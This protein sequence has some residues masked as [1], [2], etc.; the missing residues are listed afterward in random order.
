MNKI[1]LSALFSSVFSLLVTAQCTPGANY[2][3]SL[4]GAWPDTTT[5]FP[6][7]SFGVNYVTDLNFKVPSDAGDIDPAYA[8][9]TIQDFTVDSVVGL[10]D[11][12]TY[13]CNVTSCYYTGGSNGC[14][15]ISGIPASSGSHDITIHITANL[16][17]FGFPVA[18]PY[19]FD[20]YHINVSSLGLSEKKFELIS[21]YPNPA[22]DIVYLKEENLKM[23]HIEILDAFGKTV[24]VKTTDLNEL[25]ISSLDKGIYIIKIDFK[26]KQETVRFVKS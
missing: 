15:Q 21:L 22:Q 24:M 11:G 6:P 16:L 20:G 17:F 2:A 1:L 4:F 8:G 7:A 19:S 26:G 14:A 23:S 12:L 3:D 18:V 5:N 25:N 13:T 10:P 9:N